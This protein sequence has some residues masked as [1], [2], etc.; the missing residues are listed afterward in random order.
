MGELY[1]TY[2]TFFSNIR[3]KIRLFFE[4]IKV[5]VLFVGKQMNVSAMIMAMVHLSVSNLNLL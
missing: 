5:N 4:A 3:K 1:D 2:Q